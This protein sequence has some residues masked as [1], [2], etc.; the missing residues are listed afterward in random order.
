[1]IG[2]DDLVG[3]GRLHRRWI[4]LVSLALVGPARADDAGLPPPEQVVI[5][6]VMADV[7]A[8]A[9]R[10]VLVRGVVT[11]RSGTGLIIQDDTAGIWVDMPG[12]ASRRSEIECDPEGLARL[13][14]GGEV[15][16]VGWTKRGG[17]APNIAPEAIRILGT[18]PE[19]E[20]RATDA[21]RFFGGVDDCLRV[22]VAGLVQGVR[23]GGGEWHL[24]VADRG[25]R[26]QA[27][28]PKK[29][30][31]QAPEHLIDAEVRMVGVATTRYNTRGEHRGTRL[32]IVRPADL[33][34][35]RPA[36]GGP[37]EAP[38][39]P[40]RAIAQYAPESRGG[41]RI[42][43]QGLVTFCEPRRFLY[44]QQGT[45]GVRVET[46]SAERFAPGDLVEV[47]GFVNRRSEVAGIF[48]AVV[49][50]L[51]TDR[52]LQPMRIT[53]DDIVAINRKA[54]NQGT[55]ATPGDYKGCLVTFSARVVDV[56]PSGDRGAVLLHS[57]STGV[58]AVASAET[59]PELRFLEPGS[60]VQVSGIVRENTV[61]ENFPDA[62]EAWALAAVPS[63]Q[64]QLLLRSPADV[65]L[66]RAPSWW[67]PHR[68][69]VA[70][71]AVAGLAG[72]A[73]AWVVVLRQQVRRQ[74]TLIE[75]KLQSEAAT[76]ERHRIAQEFHD[77]LEQDLAG[78][79]LQL[80]AAAHRTVDPR[81]QTVLEEQRGLVARL[82]SE[83]HDFL[84]DLRDPA[85]HDG[86]LVES[87]ASQT[88]YLQS[89]A[90]VPVRLDAAAD[91]PRVPPLVQ[92]QLLR[93]VRE[94]VS[95]A[96]RHG[97]P[98]GIDLRLEASAERL[99][100]TIAD[101]GRGFDV[102]AHEAVV[103]H[104]GLRGMRERARRIGAAIE[105]ESRPERGTRVKV[106]VPAARLAMTAEPGL[107]KPTMAPAAA[108]AD[109]GRFVPPVKP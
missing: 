49:R 84:W 100:L 16:V 18:R 35:M 14:P 8:A 72:A 94:A 39:L 47:A 44:L 36:T 43:T 89:L 26:F 5:R 24:A 11:W 91:L 46:S 80:D 83:A 50:K 92:Y 10:R 81:S 64:L 17:F 21:E 107:S 73:F 2:R 60:D 7:N 9:R 27:I 93:I 23:D 54:S 19:P 65:R 30:M 108:T 55:V 75:T 33:A 62:D 61:Q 97:D 99:S 25:R 96:V 29:I 67:K 38:H 98:T 71:A 103:S 63:G 59:F 105:I 95:N 28:V 82:Q 12:E 40:L 86:S 4:M 53:P 20:P 58:V 51:A 102:A 45:M 22:S 76:E 48:E 41:R 32:L 66:I 109:H 101:D 34:L 57:G 56:Q 15:E 77:T 78:I 106:S 68:L 69:A 104:F 52:S 42:R 31:P 74:L 85:R 90:D 70:L 37:F 87:L 3:G 1:M 88:A 13:V 79:T 6:E